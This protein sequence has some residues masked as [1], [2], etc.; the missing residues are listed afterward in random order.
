LGALSLRR[1]LPRW[2]MAGPALLWWGFFFVVPIGWI[3]V[4][5]LG[6]KPATPGA[7]PVSL[8]VLSLGNYATASSGVF[9]IVFWITMRTAVLGTIACALVGFPVAYALANCVPRPLALGDAISLGAAI[10]DHPA[11]H[12]RLAHRARRPRACCRTRC[13]RWG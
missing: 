10:L 6:T 13:A 2:S 1:L 12:L 3:A 8:E 7:G 5:S 4:Y 11:A 9:L